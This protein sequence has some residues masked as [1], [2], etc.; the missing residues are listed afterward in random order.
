MI[1]PCGGETNEISVTLK[2]LR[3][4]Q[5]WYPEFRQEDLPLH[6]RIH[7]CK[8]CGRQDK[9]IRDQAVRG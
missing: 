5:R 9:E 2:T 7:R 6:L 4:A 8:A 1:C 3:G